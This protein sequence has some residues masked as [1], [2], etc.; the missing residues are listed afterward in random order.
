MKKPI[1]HKLPSCKGLRPFTKNLIETFD[2]QFVND[3]NKIISLILT[4]SVR[5]LFALPVEVSKLFISEKDLIDADIWWLL[6]Q[7]KNITSEETYKIKGF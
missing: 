1:M 7:P 6:S 4:K 3:R 2:V 5:I